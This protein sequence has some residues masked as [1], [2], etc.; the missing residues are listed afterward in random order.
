MSFTVRDGRFDVVIAAGPR[1]ASWPTPG[2]RSLSLLAAEMGLSVGMFGGEATRVRGVIPVP[3][4]GGWVLAEDSQKRIHRVQARAV[5]RVSARSEWPDP[6][7]GWRAEGLIP[8]S[9]A[10]RLWKAGAISWTPAVAILGS[11]N[12]ALRFGSDLLASGVPEVACLETVGQWGLK[13]YAG[14]E[15]ELR[16]FEMSGG[17][18][19]RG[20]PGG[21]SLKSPGL[22]EFRLEDAQGTRILEVSW[23]VTAGP[24]SDSPRVREHPPGSFLFELERSAGIS[25]EEDI[26]G[27]Q[28][29]EERGK[30]LAGRLAKSLSTG[31]GPRRDE[32]ERIVRRARARLR[33]VRRHWDEPFSPSYEG[34]WISAADRTS[35]RAFSGVPTQAHRARP[36]ASIECFEEIGCDL[37]E[38]ACPE[39]AIR[40]DPASD[41]IALSESDCTACGLCL[42]ACPSGSPVLIHEREDRSMSQL[43]LAWRGKRPFAM[44]ELGTLVN[45]KGETLGAGRVTGATV[46]G[47]V[48]CVQVE[49]PT[50]LVWEARGI[51]PAREHETEF[52]IPEGGFPEEGAQAQVT[53]NGEKRL[54][55]NRVPLSVALY[56]LA[57]NRS[58]DALLCADGSCRLCQLWVD[59]VKKLACQTVAH[60]GMVIRFED[61]AEPGS[62]R[63]LCPCVGVE[64]E[65]V[66][67]R[68]RQGKLESADAVR[69]MS[70]AGGGRCHGQVCGEPFRRAIEAAGVAADQWIDWSFPWADWVILRGAND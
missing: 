31:L 39:D 50:H 4:T 21:L 17:E 44:G 23:V 46:T 57:S 20:K 28:L 33:R 29:E 69:A 18:L 60:R 16:R 42:V 34:K 52:S 51:H 24:F 65:S 55:R 19:L 36:V 59:G 58:G 48:Q 32:L 30:W 63:M 61:Q 25:R 41:R 8:L 38:R 35:V 43:T 9:T 70:H 40:I 26:E 49:V 27:W 3:G 53:V 68:I 7:P 54:V 2:A 56:E 62:G 67:E 37:C 12:R 66:V 15:V 11:G 13:D 1:V 5:V 14:W 47:A 10:T 22:W 6:F 64:P 45:R